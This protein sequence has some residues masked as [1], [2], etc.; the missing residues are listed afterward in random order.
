[1]PGKLLEQICEGL[2]SLGIGWL[3]MMSWPGPNW[4][5]DELLASMEA[6]HHYVADR[7]KDDRM[8]DD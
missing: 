4:H 8:C 7:F 1:M 5:E 2:E 6:F 3:P